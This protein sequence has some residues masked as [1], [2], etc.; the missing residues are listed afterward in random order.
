M[1]KCEQC[2][3]LPCLKKC[4][5]VAIFSHQSYNMVQSLVTAT[6][7]QSSIVQLYISLLLHQSVKSFGDRQVLLHVH[8]KVKLVHP[9]SDD[10][11]YLRVNLDTLHQRVFLGTSHKVA[12]L[13]AS[14]QQLTLHLPAVPVAVTQSQRAILHLKVF[15]V[16]IVLNVRALYL[17]QSKW[18]LC[19]WIENHAI[20]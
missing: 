1:T 10:C 12:P 20:W 16:H 13:Q 19:E 7:C 17:N 15:T 2:P 9:L 11:C 18:W 5:F 4:L 3:K 14:D 6:E 8:I